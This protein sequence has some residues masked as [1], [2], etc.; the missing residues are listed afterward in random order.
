[1][2]ILQKCCCYYDNNNNNVYLEGALPSTFV[3][4]SVLNRA[5]S[6]TF[7]GIVDIEDIR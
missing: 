4:M 6:V 2:K 3:E 5:P 7:L 1:M